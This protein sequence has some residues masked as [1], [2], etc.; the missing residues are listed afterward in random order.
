MIAWQH[1]SLK[2]KQRLKWFSLAQMTQSVP[3]YL[4]DSTKHIT[5]D[6][7]EDSAHVHC[8]CNTIQV[9]TE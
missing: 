8:V 3:P 5:D 4:L 7:S 9:P 2:P 6:N 1:P